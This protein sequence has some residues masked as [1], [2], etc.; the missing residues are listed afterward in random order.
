MKPDDNLVSK[1]FT[2]SE[3]LISLV[4]L[5]V[6]AAFAIP[7]VL[8]SQQS[9]QEKAVFKETIA[10]LSEVYYEGSRTQTIPQ[11]V[12][13]QCDDYTYLT[14]RIN[15][16]KLCNT[17]SDAQGCW[18]DSTQGNNYGGGEV[19]EPGFVLP[20]G[21]D[22]VGLNTWDCTF[23]AFVIDWNGPAGPNVEGQD[24][25]YLM[26]CDYAPCFGGAPSLQP[27]LIQPRNAQ[28]VTL[29]SWIFSN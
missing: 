27:G 22:V 2:L 4:I 24:Q 23:G 26:R 6:I 13:N 5:G 19:N 15:A 28:D 16:L 17:A 11:N 8:V 25:L 21:A 1:G 10:T 12:S 9:Q 14:S 3:L 7:K 18:D 29:W 20:N